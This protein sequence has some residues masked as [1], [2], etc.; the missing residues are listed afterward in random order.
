MQSLMEMLNPQQKQILN[1][2][3]GKTDNEKAEYIARLL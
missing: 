2:L 3:Q 1:N